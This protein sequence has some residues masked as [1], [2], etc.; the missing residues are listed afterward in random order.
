MGSFNGLVDLS[1]TL[2]VGQVGGGRRVG[3][4]ISYGGHV[5]S[6]WK[7]PAVFISHSKLGELETRVCIRMCDTLD[8][9]MW[10]SVLN[11]SLILDGVG[12]EKLMNDFGVGKKYGLNI[13]G[14]INAGSGTQF[15]RQDTSE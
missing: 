3:K 8:R 7:V 2:K 6:E 10:W 12:C 15:L 9:P 4:G 14:Q 11:N 5:V 13:L 1:W